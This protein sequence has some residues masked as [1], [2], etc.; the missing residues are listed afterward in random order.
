[1]HHLVHG[2]IQFVP[3]PPS[4]PPLLPPSLTLAPTHSLHSSTGPSIRVPA[5]ERVFTS[6]ETMAAQVSNKHSFSPSSAPPSPPS[7]PPSPPFRHPPTSSLYLLALSLAD[8]LNSRE[9]GC[10]RCT[11][12]VLLSH[13]ASAFQ[14][15][16][17][18]PSLPPSLPPYHTGPGAPT[19]SPPPFQ[20]LLC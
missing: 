5:A 6:Q 3:L 13:S 1:M 9:G 10:L 7:L 11:L 20:S 16:P 12:Y 17:L 15:L 14:T 8:T 19:A 2:F 4:I 18:P